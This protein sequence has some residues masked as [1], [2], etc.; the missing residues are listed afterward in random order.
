VADQAQRIAQSQLLADVVL[1]LDR[2]CGGQRHA[3]HVRRLVEHGLEL[4]VLGAEVVAP[5][6][7]AVGL[8]DG[9]QR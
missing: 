4:A 9:D 1:H 5:M 2:G 6:G 8:V 7:H 3:R